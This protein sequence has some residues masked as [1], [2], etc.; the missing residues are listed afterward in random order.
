MPA[1]TSELESQIRAEIL[2]AFRAQFGDAWPQNLT[3]NLRPSPLKDI[4]VRHGVSL[5]AVQ[6]VKH[7]IWLAGL[8]L[9]Q[10][11]PLLDETTQ[12]AQVS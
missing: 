1:L 10:L 9:Q 3:R 6:E 5:K 12:S 4:A 2:A 11:V 7:K 8:R